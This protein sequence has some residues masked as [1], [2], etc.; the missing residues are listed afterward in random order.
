[1]K[2]PIVQFSI[3][4]SRQDFGPTQRATLFHNITKL[5]DPCVQNPARYYSV[6]RNGG[7]RGMRVQLRDEYC[8]LL[9]GSVIVCTLEEG[10]P[11]IINEKP[12]CIREQ[13]GLRESRLW[14]QH[15]ISAEGSR[16]QRQHVRC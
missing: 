15:T 11:V 13:I 10:S 12:S 14:H 7:E 9:D 2:Y 6:R 1:M 5:Q 16:I 3:T 8:G 4:L